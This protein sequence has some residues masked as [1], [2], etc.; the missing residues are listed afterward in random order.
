MTTNQTDS[1]QVQLSALQLTSGADAQANLAKV[2]HWLQQLPAE[3][4]QLV[5]LPEAFSCFGAG[6]RAQ[7]QQAE[8]LGDGTTQTRL[9]ELA[10][11]YGVWLVAGTIPIQVGD[12]TQ[13]RFTAS[14]LVFDPEGKRRASYN[15]VHLFDV[16]VADQTRTYHESKYTNPGTEVVVVDTDFG[17][18]GL[19]VCYDV[20]FP[21][22]F[23]ALRDAGAEIIVLPSAFTQ[24][25][26]AAHWHVLTRARAI[27]QQCYL[28]AAGQVGIH[29]NGRE[30]YGH[31]LIVNGWGEIIAEQATAEGVVTA[32]VDLTDLDDI[33]ANIPVA[34]HN[35]FKV[36]YE[37]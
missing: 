9:A 6:D 17:R 34:T 11:R 13:E 33:R 12:G 10:K 15:K 8:P 7:A 30:T 35:K 19:A 29:Q 26:G 25:T 23:R 3:R 14:C 27:E 28:V 20:R 21:E 31:S 2:E 32:A 4:P 5:V 16:S 24:V 22:L 18:V 37:R 1:R 36:N